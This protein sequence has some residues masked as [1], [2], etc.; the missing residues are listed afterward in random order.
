MSKYILIVLLMGMGILSCA[1]ASEVGKTKIELGFWGAGDFSE[2]DSTH[3]I[4]YFV[5]GT[6]DVIVR[7]LPEG[8]RPG[9]VEYQGITDW[10]WPQG[11]NLEVG[12]TVEF[13]DQYTPSAILRE[14]LQFEYYVTRSQELS[15]SIWRATGETP[16]RGSTA[17]EYHF[18]FRVPPEIAGHFLWIKASWH[19][20]QYGYLPSEESANI[21]VAPVCSERDQHAVWRTNVHAAAQK[22][23]FNLA[24]ELA[25]SFIASGWRDWAGLIDAEYAATYS[26]R[27]NDAIRFLDLYYQTYGTV[28]PPQA[29]GSSTERGQQNYERARAQLIEL[30]SQQQQR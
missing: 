1:R 4:V 25:D 14:Q 9:E 28:A 24:V 8:Q 2:C 22:K 29:R 27:Y 11:L 16:P 5:G 30:Q 3:G 6:Y 23:D 19:H 18:S 21:R 10:T 12:S 17:P 7:L 13:E 15:D 26:E 20:N